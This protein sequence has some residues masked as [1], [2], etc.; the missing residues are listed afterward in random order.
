MILGGASE[1]VSGR[2]DLANS[3]SRGAWAYCRPLWIGVGDLDRKCCSGILGVV[4][5]RVGGIRVVRI[6]NCSFLWN[7][8]VVAVGFNSGLAPRKAFLWL[9]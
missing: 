3:R 9:F 2:T 8:L 5:V 4:L 7:L 1:T 6:L